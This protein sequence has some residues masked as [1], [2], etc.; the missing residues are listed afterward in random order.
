MK[1][2]KWLSAVLAVVMLLTMLLPVTALAADPDREARQAEKEAELA[3]LAPDASPD[4]GNDLLTKDVYNI[5]L[6]GIDARYDG[7]NTRNDATMIVSINNT[8][9]EVILTS[10][11]RDAAIDVPGFGHDR[12]NV[13]NV[14]GGAELS[15][16]TVELNY[17]VK[18]DKYIMVNFVS[19]PNVVKALGGVDIELTHEEVDN[20]N[21]HVLTG[22]LNY[23][24]DNV[25][26]LDPDQALWFVRIRDDST[27]IVRTERQ[28]RFLTVVWE[29]AKAMSAEELFEL[30]KVV[31]K[32]TN[33]DLD[34]GT[35]IALISRLPEL[36][37]YDLV[38]DRVP[39]DGTWE[40]GN[41]GGA[42]YILFDVDENKKYLQELIYGEGQ[43]A[44][45][46]ALEKTVG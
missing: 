30:A 40:F 20:I 38:L 5:L 15:E 41:V 37:E 12:L 39:V 24:D 17:G 22:H 32:E 3:D 36:L 19:F 9:K 31:Y 29:M 21:G 46:A 10:L 43:E 45:L 14:Y 18:A 27:D 2:K 23:T 44:A 7:Y 34:L 6:M 13:T 26:H 8:R 33:S 42:S 35:L 4:P 11:Q 25:Y 16:K 1:E 28:R